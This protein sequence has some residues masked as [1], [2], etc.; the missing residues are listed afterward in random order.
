[1]QK[2]HYVYRITNTK[3]NKHYYGS[4]SSKVEPKLDLGIKYFSS[5]SDKEFKNEQKENKSIFKY[6]VIKI[7]ETRKEANMY[8]H[9]LHT[10]FQVHVNKK[11]YNL[12]ISRGGEKFAMPD[13]VYAKDLITGKY[14][15]VSKQS[16]INNDNLVTDMY[17]MRNYRDLKT[18]LISRISIDEINLNPD[19]YEPADKN[20]VTVKNILNNKTIK[21][22]YSEFENNKFLVGPRTK[23]F[24]FYDNN[25]YRRN[26]INRLKINIFDCYTISK[27]IYIK[28][29]HGEIYVDNL[30]ETDLNKV[31]QKMIY[32]VEKSTFNIIRII[33]KH[34]DTVLHSKKIKMVNVVNLISN[35]IERVSLYEYY[36]RKELLLKNSSKLFVTQSNYLVRLC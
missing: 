26:D 6:K 19:R 34:F 20:M 2:Y 28:I 18:G 21:V 22:S 36:K 32:V 23:Y 9:L 15:R 31:Y 16:Y 7:F 3:E 33:P 8:E 13:T 25:V 1:M 11:F 29:M 12:S 5:S 14:I 30:I 35:T 27:E 24:Y 17:N 4:R 10:R